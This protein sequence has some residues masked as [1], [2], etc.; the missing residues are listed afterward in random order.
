MKRLYSQPR[1]SPTGICWPSRRG[2]AERGRA[3]AM[4]HYYILTPVVHC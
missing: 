2:A 1:A 3:T 4:I